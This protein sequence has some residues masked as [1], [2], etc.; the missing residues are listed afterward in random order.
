MRDFWTYHWV[1]LWGIIF[2]WGF[3]ELKGQDMEGYQRLKSSGKVPAYFQ[4]AFLEEFN[5]FVSETDTTVSPESQ[6]EFW[7]ESNQY[8]NQLFLSGKVLYNDPVT[9]YLNQ[10]ADHLLRK[11]SALRRKLRFFAVRSPSINAFSSNQG[12]VLV[13]L[14]L[15]ARLENEAQ[16]AF[17]LSHEISHIVRKHQRDFY[18]ASQTLEDQLME[19]KDRNKIKQL[20]LQHQLYSQKTEREADADGLNIFLESNYDPTLAPSCFDILISRNTAFA[21]S[22]FNPEFLEFNDFRLPSPYFSAPPD[23][24]PTQGPVYAQDSQSSHPAA[25]DRKDLLNRALAQKGR[26]RSSKKDF[27]VGKESFEKIREICRFETCF[28]LLAE[29]QYE[30]SLYWSYLLSLEHPSN[31]FLQRAM[32]YALYGISK[33]KLSGRFYDIHSNYEEIMGKAK[34]LFFGFEQLSPEASLGLA[35]GNT[36]KTLQKYPKDPEL[37]AIHADLNR[38]FVQLYPDQLKSLLNADFSHSRSTLSE[39]IF[40]SL[41]KNEDFLNSFKASLDTVQQQ[42]LISQQAAFKKPNAITGT[43]LGL[44]KVAIV[45][46][47]YF[48][49]DERFSRKEQ[50]TLANRQK[51]HL[52]SFLLEHA[53]DL[54]L[55]LIILSN[56]GLE[57]PKEFEV[58]DLLLLSEWFAEKNR[59]AN[60]N[61]VSLYQQEVQDLVEKYGTQHFM[62]VEAGNLAR[63]PSG[64]GLILS[65]GIL[66]PVL[67]PYTILYTRTP[68]HLTFLYAKVYDLSTGNELAHYPQKLLMRDRMDVLRSASYNLLFQI[69]SQP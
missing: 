30:K 12:V 26:V 45:N 67:L 21:D 48:K 62:W 1:S 28:S 33:H 37:L 61:M 22:F 60:L 69:S 65:A 9:D 39:K 7:E 43:S 2:L 29:E 35:L 44:E 49:I 25:L 19:V 54:D 56:S 41:F 31:S 11:N 4:I 24:F 13:N 55:E 52:E 8:I 34:N 20:L 59:R 15:I 27:L 63:S 10:V 51:Y 6:E 46:P 40:W 58:E 57:T 5:P 17:I 53:S 14:G 47:S 66:L 32:V 3:T 16:L 64:K 50:I 18:L 68:K 38:E 42:L 36:W 23:S